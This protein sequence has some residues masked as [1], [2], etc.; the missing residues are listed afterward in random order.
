MIGQDAVTTAEAF[1]EGVGF[2]GVVL[3]KL[4][5]DARGGAA[6][7]VREVTGTPILFAS[8]G[9]KLED[10]DV[11]HPDRMASRIL[12]MGDVL[13]LI[14]QA[15]QVFDAEQAEAAAAKIGTGE[16]TLEDFLEQMLAIRKM[17]PIGNLLGMLP[18]AGSDE[19]CAGRRRRQ[20]A[21]PRAGDHPR[22]D[23]GRAGRPED[24]QRV[25]PVADRQRF[26]RCG[27]GGQSARRPVLRG[28]Q[29]DVADGGSDGHA[30][31]AQGHPARPPRARARRARR[32]GGGRRRRR[33]ATRSAR[34]Y[35]CRLPGSVEH[36]QGPRRAA[37]RPCRH[38]PVEA[39]VPRRTSDERLRDMQRAER[40]PTPR[41]SCPRSWIAGE[42]GGVVD[43]RRHAVRRAGQRCGNGLRC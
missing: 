3:T 11:F 42:A 21:R 6:L 24:H 9:E 33:R 38:R 4:D 26:W 17:G 5:G 16:L 12:G 32:A 20:P 36:A 22:H 7:S 37:A 28:P 34:R 14:E 41:P 40:E 18:G 43:R 27:V 2:T 23:T 19:G 8:A 25:A 15:E 31:R 10:F 30:V 35:A 1:R 29:D 39:E 13:T